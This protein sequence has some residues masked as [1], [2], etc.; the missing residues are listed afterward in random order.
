L[1]ITVEGGAV[2]FQALNWVK[3]IQ[4]GDSSARFVAYML[5]NYAD[6]EGS[7]YPTIAMLAADTDLADRT[8]RSAI[9]RLTDLGLVAVVRQ[10]NGD[11]TLGRNR[12]RLALDETGPKADA[13][14]AKSA[15]GE[16]GEAPA[17]IDDHPAATDDHPA[18]TA[19]GPI[20]DKPPSKPPLE[21]SGERERAGARTP[22]TGE[23][24]QPDG[25]TSSGATSG[26]GANKRSSLATERVGQDD[27]R[28]KRWAVFWRKWPNTVVD[29]RDA[30]LRAWRD[31]PF[32]QLQAAI[33]GIEPFFAE[34][35]RKG[36]T[37]P[38]SA[39]KY[40]QQAKWEGVLKPEAADGQVKVLGPWTKAWIAVL[41]DMLEAGNA[42]AA[43]SM[44][45][46]AQKGQ[47]RSVHPNRSKTAELLKRAEGYRLIPAHHD[48]WTLF[49]KW[50]VRRST[51]LQWRVVLPDLPSTDDKPF[52]VAVPPDDVC[53]SLGI[54]P[55]TPEAKPPTDDEV[56]EAFAS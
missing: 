24:D 17:A 2:S 13:P 4:L 5:A 21:P 41:V 34:S 29:D 45:Q 39:S 27:E 33:D 18:A 11:G 8:V 40:L 56:A 12:Y 38:L 44:V 10:R 22:E 32:D 14:A 36:R 35:K 55:L 9:K 37:K 53:R 52:F 51:D 15:G 28:K 25:S 42:R 1:S 19:A 6:E 20:K 31:V 26:G 16:G 47:G 43:R 48:G 46:F 30:A 54:Q 3:S 49:A 7:C 23:G 50:V